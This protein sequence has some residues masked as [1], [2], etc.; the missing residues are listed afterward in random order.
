LLHAD[1]RT[2]R[3]TD[4]SKLIVALRNFANAPEGLN[5]TRVFLSNT[6]QQQGICF[7]TCQQVST[8]SSIKFMVRNRHGVTTHITH[9]LTLYHVPQTCQVVIYIKFTLWASIQPLSYA[10][11]LNIHTF[12]IMLNQA[13]C[14]GL[15]PPIHILPDIYAVDK[16]SGR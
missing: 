4:M 10:R 9:D 5:E 8:K 15:F 11:S 13:R 6:L 3:Q 16:K 1:G 12:T 2:E 14:T 7:G